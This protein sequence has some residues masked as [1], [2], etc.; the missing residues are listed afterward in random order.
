MFCGN[1]GE[2]LSPASADSARSS[3]NHGAAAPHLSRAQRPPQAPTQPP[4]PQPTAAVQSGSV[5]PAPS[6]VPFPVLASKRS[7]PPAL[8]ATLAVLI[9]VAFA[10]VAS[11]IIL[12][13]TASDNAQPGGA[14]TT[15]TVT[16]LG[17][18]R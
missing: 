15:T 6:A 13:F 5:W 8:L 11:A 18:A 16:V 12:A 14:T 10:G 17:S 4:R 7:H 1:C 3:V 9:V 2:A